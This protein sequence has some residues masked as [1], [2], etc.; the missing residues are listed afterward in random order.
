MLLAT[1]VSL[2]P[3]ASGL[4]GDGDVPGGTRDRSPAQKSAKAPKKSDPFAEAIRLKRQASG[5]SAE[6][7]FVALTAA[8][9]ACEEVAK[10]TFEPAVVAEAHW[11][12]GELWRTLR[13]EENARRSFSAVTGMAAAD[14][15]LAAK[16]WLEIGHLDRRA[17]RWDAAIAS[18]RRVLEVE[19][20]QRRESAQSLTWQGKSLLS[21]GATADGHALLLVVGQRFPDLPLEDIRNVDQV[22]CDWIDAGRVEEARDLVA[23]CIARHS[24]NPGDAEAEGGADDDEAAEARAAITRAISKMKAGKQ[25]AEKLTKN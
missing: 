19:P 22:A 7:K 6:E 20:Q 17:K 18:Y 1:L 2:L 3:L 12:A 25:L 13:H 24:E 15:R 4:F 14:P 5:K 8:A 11:R 21:K 10:G 23:A 9:K 16:A